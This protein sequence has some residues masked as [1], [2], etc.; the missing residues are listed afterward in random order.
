M[1]GSEQIE[2]LI[3]VIAAFDRETLV[4]HINSYKA[5]FPLDFTPE[6]LASHPLERLRHIFLAVCLHTKRMPELASITTPEAA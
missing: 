3:C 1:L 4:K 6:F 5:C 2:E